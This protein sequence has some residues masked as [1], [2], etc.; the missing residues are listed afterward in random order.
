[1]YEY[2][3]LDILKCR[4]PK[5]SFDFIIYPGLC[6]CAQLLSHIWLFMTPW[7]VICQALL[8]MGFP[9]QE[10]LEWG[11]ISFF[12]ESSQ[13][14]DRTRVSCINRQTLYHWANLGSPI[15]TLIYIKRCIEGQKVYS[16]ARC[17]YY[18]NLSDTQDWYNQHTIA[19]LY[20]GSSAVC[21]VL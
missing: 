12:R 6:M 2:H 14:R 19:N 15:L 17:L 11:A 5:R 16:N 10:Y 18:I 8:S 21:I 9:R 4:M 20:Q 13:P 1:M 7:T 3:H